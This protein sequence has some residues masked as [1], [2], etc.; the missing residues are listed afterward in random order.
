REGMYP[1]WRCTLS[2]WEHLKLVATLAMPSDA[3]F[4][5]FLPDGADLV[6]L[7]SGRLEIWRFGDGTWTV[8]P[9]RSMD[10][11][12]TFTTAEVG[13]VTRF[14]PWVR[15]SSQEI[16]LLVPSDGAIHGLEVKGTHLQKK[17][18][19][20]VGPRSFYHSGSESRPLE[21]PFW[22]RGSLWYP[23]ANLGAF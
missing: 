20:S 7:R 1:D 5:G 2:V 11:H 3:L 14:R 8:D 12:A 15:L 10:L 13:D 22:V 21:L 19:F 9:N 17:Y 23:A 16:I 6:L 18:L 4:Y